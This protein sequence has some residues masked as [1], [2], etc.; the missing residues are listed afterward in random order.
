MCV[1]VVLCDGVC[2]VFLCFLCVCWGRRVVCG[3]IY[4]GVCML[5]VV[6]SVLLYGF[7]VY[8]VCV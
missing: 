4:K 5:F 3:V 8:G 1:C 6:F 2:F 7:V